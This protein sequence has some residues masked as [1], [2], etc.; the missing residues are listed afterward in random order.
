MNKRHF[1]IYTVS[2]VLL[3]VSGVLGQDASSVSYDQKI[4]L[5]YG[6]VH[7]T[8]LLMD[9]F[10]PKGK[11]N[12]L[13]II[14]V[15]SGAFFSDRG[16]IR[17]HTMG[18]IY[19]IFCAR[20]YTVF[21]LRPGSKTRYTGQEM[22][23]NIKTGIRYV[24]Q[25]AA[26]YK[27]DPDNLGITGASAGGHLATLVAVTPEESKGEGASARPG[28][29]VKAAA[30]FFPP[31]DFLDWDGKPANLAVIGD[32]LFLGGAKGHSDEELKEKAEQIS[33][34]RLVKTKP[35]PFLL[36]HG[37]ADPTVPLQQSQKMVEVLK[38]AGGSAELVIKKGGGHPWMTIYEEVKVMADWFDKQLPS[39][40][41][42]SAAQK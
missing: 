33:P 28:T 3:A 32:L 30:V 1:I 7:G 36:I 42:T 25:H 17:E 18:R 8:G 24:K 15:V 11:S 35:V 23:A 16:K 19:Q 39:A 40:G 12:G 21:A 34:A 22:A 41:E 37:D 26:E 20:G 5:V 10:T 13:A 4:D 9:V 29:H 31:T 38:A 2:T 6:E 27:I 14:D